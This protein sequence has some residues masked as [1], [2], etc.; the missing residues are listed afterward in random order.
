MI[1]SKISVRQMIESDI[2]V[3]AHAVRQ[4]W[5]RADAEHFATETACSFA[6]SPWRPHFYTALHDADQIIGCAGYG[7]SWIGYNCYSIMWVSV[8]PAWQQKGVG[9][10]LV[11]RCLNDLRAIATLVTLST[12]KPDFYEQHWGFRQLHAFPGRQ[13]ESAQVLMSLVL[14]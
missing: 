6:S 9:K 11:S 12:T 1:M 8:F 7:P 3:L 5:S 2:P 13:D 4:N 10:M 14:P